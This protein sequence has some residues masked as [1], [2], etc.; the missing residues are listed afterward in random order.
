MARATIEFKRGD[1]TTHYFHLPESDWA[2]GGKL[3]FIAKPQVDNDATDAAAVIN[4]SFSDSDII[5]EGHSLYQEGYKTYELSFSPSDTNNI[6]FDD[7]ES[8]KTY[9]GEFQY[10]SSGGGVTSYP[11]TND[12]LE[13]VVYG[14]LR[15]RTN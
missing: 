11:G 5:D 7:G 2:A 12:F 4:K 3:S 1:G 9:L 8:S 10:V 13:V 15:R 6:T 14:D